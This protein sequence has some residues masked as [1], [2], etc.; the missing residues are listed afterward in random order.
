[1]VRLGVAVAVALAGLI[2][3]APVHSQ[4]LPQHIEPPSALSKLVGN[5]QIA[6]DHIVGIDLYAEGGPFSLVYSDYRTGVIRRL[7]QSDDAVQA[8]HACATPCRRPAP[9]VRPAHTIFLWTVSAFLHVARP[10]RA[11]LRQA[12]NGCL[13]RPV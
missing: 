3:V 6:P 5:Y 8:V 10:R 4:P 2:V 9:R 11:R 7:S 12:R 1:M 13:D